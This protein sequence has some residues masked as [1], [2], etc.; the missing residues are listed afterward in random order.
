MAKETSFNFLC[1]KL[2]LGYLISSAEFA[3]SR[4]GWLEVY[5]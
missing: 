2:K 3:S 4:L 5:S 1:L